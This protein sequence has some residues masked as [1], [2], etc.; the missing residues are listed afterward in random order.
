[1]YCNLEMVATEN[2]VAV[3]KHTHYKIGIGNTKVENKM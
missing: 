2:N 3:I 1:M